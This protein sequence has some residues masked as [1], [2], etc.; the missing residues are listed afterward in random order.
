MPVIL[1]ISTVITCIAVWFSQSMKRT[2]KNAVRSELKRTSNI[3]PEPLTEQDISHLPDI[4][5]KY[6]RFT[7]SIGKHK[8][9]NFRTECNGG[10]RFSPNEEFMTL[11]SVQNNFLND[12]SRLFC[13]TAKKSGIPAIGLHIYQKA[14]AIFKVK[15]LG[16]IPVVNAFGTKMN[17]GESVTVLN[18]ICFMAPGALIDNRITWEMIDSTTVKAVF[19][20]KGIIISAQLFFTTDGKLVNFISN[21][22]F[23]TDGKVYHNYPWETPVLEY[24]EFDG[25]L[26][27]SKVKLIFKRKDGDFC[28]GEF[29]LVSV[30]YNV[31]Q[32]KPLRG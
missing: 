17:Q 19:T 18:D 4:V 26:L 14:Q 12:H 28:Y 24:K 30:E 22:R 11:R 27:P 15:I 3:N 32:L 20:N 2:Y 25:Y 31:K 21:D 13:I 16:L 10:I 29:N 23:E 5:K 1:L 6:I 8:V 7:G 9:V